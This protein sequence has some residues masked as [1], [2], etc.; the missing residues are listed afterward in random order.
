MDADDK[1]QVKDEPNESGSR[2]E[3]DREFPPSAAPSLAQPIQPPLSCTRDGSRDESGISAAHDVATAIE[4]WLACIARADQ[5]EELSKQADEITPIIKN[6]VPCIDQLQEAHG[7]NLAALQELSR[8]L[9]NAQRES[10]R[11]AIHTPLD[12]WNFIADIENSGPPDLFGH[13]ALPIDSRLRLLKQRVKEQLA[14]WGVYPLG[15]LEGD[16]FDPKTMTIERAVPSSAGL[17]YR[18]V[19]RVIRDGWIHQDA[20]G[21][22]CMLQRARVDVAV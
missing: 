11:I 13:H 21:A 10:W 16:L 4:R 14:T 6:L 9:K 22:T 5:T 2:S 19:S 1:S 15:V 12:T 20:L 17:R 3:A 8:E 18:S 7:Q